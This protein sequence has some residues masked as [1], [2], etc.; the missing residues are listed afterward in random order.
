MG[1]RTNLDGFGGLQR[2]LRRYPHLALPQQLLC[3]VGDVSAGDGDVFNAAADDV[4]F[5]LH[6]AERVRGSRQC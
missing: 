1:K 2:L 5:S 6:T 4:A 3:E